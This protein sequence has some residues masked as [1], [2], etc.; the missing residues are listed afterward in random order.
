MGTPSLIQAIV[1][2]ANKFNVSTLDIEKIEYEDG[3]GMSFNYRI[4]GQ[5][6]AYIR[7]TADDLKSV[8]MLLRMGIAK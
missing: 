5:Q 6:Q 7:L 1:A 3:S 2:I 8:N 4:K